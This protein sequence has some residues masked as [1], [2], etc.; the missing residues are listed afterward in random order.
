MAAAVRRTENLCAIFEI[1]QA[2]NETGQ[3]V[4]KLKEPQRALIEFIAKGTLDGCPLCSQRETRDKML[5]GADQETVQ[6]CLRLEMLA[7]KAGPLYVKYLLYDGGSV[8]DIADIVCGTTNTQLRKIFIDRVVHSA[9][10]CTL[11]LGIEYIKMNR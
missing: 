2:T 5:M 9:A 1:Q 6:L 8:H 4:K 10:I 11:L 7:K 3:R